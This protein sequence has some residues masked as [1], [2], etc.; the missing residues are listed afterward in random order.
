MIR[1]R[2]VIASSLPVTRYQGRR[3]QQPVCAGRGNPA[4]CSMS[5]V[6][7]IGPSHISGGPRQAKH[8]YHMLATTDG[9][10][11]LGTFPGIRQYRY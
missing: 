10:L 2:N 7:L 5:H 8:N 1:N 6:F 3:L 9:W 11:A 4:P